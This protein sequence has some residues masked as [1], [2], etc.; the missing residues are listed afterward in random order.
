M[1][2]QNRHRPNSQLAILNH[3]PTD[4]QADK[5]TINH[6]LSEKQGHDRLHTVEPH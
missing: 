4:Q 6:R 5:R 2:I 3:N 1:P